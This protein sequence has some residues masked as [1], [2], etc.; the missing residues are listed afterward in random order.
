MSFL[1]TPALM[2]YPLPRLVF[3]LNFNSNVILQF[4][5]IVNSSAT[6]LGAVWQRFSVF[7]LLFFKKESVTSVT[8]STRLQRN[9]FTSSKTSPRRLEN[10]LKTSSRGLGRWKIVTLKTSSRRLEDISWRRLQTS[11]RQ[12][13]CLLGI[14]VSDKSIFHKSI[15]EKSKVNPKCVT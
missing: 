15:S 1:L 6:E 7:F 9:N 2:K 4:L 14:S 8:S 12:T 3:P 11:W 5:L 10:F 13:K